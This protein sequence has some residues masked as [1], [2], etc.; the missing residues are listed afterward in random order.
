M[1]IAG[2]WSE[3]ADAAL[4][5][6]MLTNEPGLDIAPVHDRQVCVL[7]PEDWAAWLFLTGRRRNAATAAGGDVGGGGGKG[8]EGLSGRPQPLLVECI[9]RKD[10]VS[11]LAAIENCGMPTLCSP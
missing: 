9:W 8:G 7:K 4:S 10:V 5:F 3:D 11:A 2:L 1:G 6:T